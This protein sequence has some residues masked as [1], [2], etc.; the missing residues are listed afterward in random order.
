M[1]SMDFGMGVRLQLN[2]LHRASY[3]MSPLNL[4][5]R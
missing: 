4:S 5:I 2:N 3:K 1:K